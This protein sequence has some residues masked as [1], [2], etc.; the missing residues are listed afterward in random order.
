VAVEEKLAGLPKREQ[1]FLLML[2]QGWPDGFIQEALGI[3]PQN[4]RALKDRLW[5]HFLEAGRNVN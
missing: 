3:K 4:Y 5:K 2:L 1:S